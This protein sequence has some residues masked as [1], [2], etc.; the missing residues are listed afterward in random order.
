MQGH[1]HGQ[2]GSM[3]SENVEVGAKSGEN[4]FSQG[5]KEML[6]SAKDER[7]LRH[8]EALKRRR[9]IRKKTCQRQIEK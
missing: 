5:Q 4:L 3:K 8:D 9:S 6:I 2:P 7:G 1:I